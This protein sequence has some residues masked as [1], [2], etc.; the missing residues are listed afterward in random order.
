MR[1]QVHFGL[2]TANYLSHVSGGWF[3]VSLLGLAFSGAITIV[4]TSCFLYPA[5]GL[6]PLPGFDAEGFPLCIT[7]ELAECLDRGRVLNACWV[8]SSAG[9]E[10]SE[11]SGGALSDD[12]VNGAGVQ[13]GIV[14]AALKLFDGKRGG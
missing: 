5:S 11:G 2:L 8:Q 9:L 4:T 12:A 13:A 14:Q 3:E 6:S 1:R 7:S 10:G